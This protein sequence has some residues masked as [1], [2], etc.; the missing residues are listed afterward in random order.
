MSGKKKKILL[1]SP[2]P[3][4][5]NMYPHLRAFINELRQFYEIA[6][7]CFPERGY[8]WHIFAGNLLNP[9]TRTFFGTIKHILRL[10]KHGVLL[11]LERGKA[12]AVIAIDNFLY[13]LC[14]K[15]F[16]R[17]KVILWSHDF[18]S[19]DQPRKNFFLQ[20][21]IAQLTADA[22]F[23]RRNLIIQD[24]ARFALLLSSI[25][26]KETTAAS[27]VFYLPVSLPALPIEKRKAASCPVLMQLGGINRNMGSL[28]LLQCYQE[29]HTSFELYL[30]GFITNEF[31][32]CF[33]NAEYLPIVSSVPVQAEKL[34]RIVGKAD[35]GFVFYNGAHDLNYFNARN[36]SGQLVEFLRQGKPVI[37]GGCNNLRELMQEYDI[38]VFIDDVSEVGNAVAYIM[39]RYH[40]YSELCAKLFSDR[41]DIARYAKMFPEWLGDRHEAL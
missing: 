16:A 34:Y 40:H 38:G 11:H 25:P 29:Q 3:D 41:Y 15:I 7:H 5:A 21:K 35:I 17:E 20:S 28:D 27:N 1:V 18:I 6:Y 32:E 8:N 24:N 4:D 19:Y 10:L 23:R 37:A 30:H 39:K 12:D 22:L 33:D 2:F 13:V 14:D 9:F 26:M 36:A 31:M